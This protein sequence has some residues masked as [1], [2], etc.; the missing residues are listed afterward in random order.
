VAAKNGGPSIAQEFNIED[1]SGARRA[2]A[3][4]SSK[5][6]AARTRMKTVSC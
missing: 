3:S 4:T 5:T 6:V 1:D 2:G